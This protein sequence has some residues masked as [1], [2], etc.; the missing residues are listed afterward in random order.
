MGKL[1]YSILSPSARPVIELKMTSA[2]LDV[3]DYMQDYD[4]IPSSYVKAAFGHPAFTKA[5][6]GDFAKAHLVRVPKGYNHLNARY[7]PRPL[8]LTELARRQLAAYGRLRKHDRAN[9]HFSHAYLRSVIQHSFSRAPKEY[10]G[11]TI[12]TEADILA[13]PNT[14]E[15]TRSDPTPSWFVSRGHVVRPDAPIFGYEYQGA[16]MYFHGF[17]ADRATERQTA[18]AGF[19]RKTIKEML[20]RY[21]E[22]VEHGIYRQKYGL[23]QITILIV[24]IGEQRLAN[25]LAIL[26]DEVADVRIQRRFAFKSLPNFLTDDPLPTP[27]A[28]MV[29]EPWR[30][31]DGQFSIIETLK[32]VARRKGGDTIGS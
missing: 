24:T 19:E 12:H 2:R 23:S 17:E 16:F 18:K 30:R 21:A 5:I 7:R 6:L 25:M 13:H 1:R 9:D 31:V 14:P 8:E 28:H 15:T 27:T 26:K 3:L 11:L 32:L 29:S 20:L 10:P 4:V 22:Y